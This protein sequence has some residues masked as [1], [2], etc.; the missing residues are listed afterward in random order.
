VPAVSFG[1]AD[2]AQLTAIQIATLR[3]IPAPAPGRAVFAI[4][5]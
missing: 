2:A 3:Q 4:S 5:K 1:S